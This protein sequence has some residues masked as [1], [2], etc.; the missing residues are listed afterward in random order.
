VGP[1][2][3]RTHLGH[4]ERAGLGYLLGQQFVASGDRVVDVQPRLA[5]RARLLDNGA[6]NKNDPKRRPVGRGGRAAGKALVGGDKRGPRRGDEVVGAPAQDLAG[7]RTKAAN[8]LHAV[9]LELLPGG[10]KGEI[11]AATVAR[12]LQLG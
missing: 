3:A 9:I 11:Y 1:G 4:R 6:A 7:S 12:L 2:L 8:Q 5:A 10:Y